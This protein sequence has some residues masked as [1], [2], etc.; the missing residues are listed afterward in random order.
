MQI[1]DYLFSTQFLLRCWIT[2]VAV[3][4]LPNKGAGKSKRKSKSKASTV[5][6]NEPSN[7]ER[8]DT[9]SVRTPPGLNGAASSDLALRAPE[10]PSMLPPAERCQFERTA[11]QGRSGDVELAPIAGAR[12][13]MTPSKRK[14]LFHTMQP[15]SGKLQK[16]TNNVQRSTRLPCGRQEE[17]YSS[18]S[19]RNAYSIPVS[20]AF[21]F[22]AFS[23][24]LLQR[25]QREDTCDTDRTLAVETER[26]IKIETEVDFE[27]SRV[28]TQGT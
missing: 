9:G 1:I 26:T 13:P 28:G 5:G 14:A 16:V 21:N 15:T 19:G 2:R 17:V 27:E 6:M 20:P 10:V 23:P 12:S 8:S 22:P 4:T 24:G 7:N 11:A 3:E 25:G 18:I